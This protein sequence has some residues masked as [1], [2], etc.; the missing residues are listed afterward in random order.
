MQWIT[1][2]GYD[3]MAY[4]RFPIEACDE[5]QCVVFWNNVEGK[6]ARVRLSN[7][8][9]SEKLVLEWMRLAVADGDMIDVEHATP[10]TL[11]GSKKIELQAGQTVLSDEVQLSIPAGK[12]LAV[13]SYLR[14][15]AHIETA[16]SCFPQGNT[17]V[18]LWQGE[19]KAI[20]NWNAETP[21]ARTGLLQIQPENQCFY[22][23]AQVLVE[24]DD[25]VR[26]LACFGDS[27]THRS[28]WTAP[29]AKRLFAR[30]PGSVSVVNHGVSG[31]RILRD[32]SPFSQ[33]GKW[34]G[35][36]GRDRFERDV[37]VGERVDCVTVL[38]G[39]NDIFHPLAGDA[40]LSETVTAD[41]L[42]AGLS[43]MASVAHAHGATICGCTIT[44]FKDAFGF[45][46]AKAERV[47]TD[48]NEWL[49]RESPF[50]ACLDF[51]LYLRDPSDPERML[52]VYDCG[53]HV[54]PGAMGG[55]RIAEQIDLELLTRLL[56]LKQ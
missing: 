11:G 8:F 44:P 7:A 49:R 34:F 55:E 13:V 54:H 53:D 18:T 26:T 1:T 51:G 21:Q 5:T 3:P 10:V 19:R 2:W 6:R 27:I 15:E 14:S 48:V 29:L 45:W 46:N 35:P 39:I 16:C 9:S 50:D 42:I 43:A 12:R 36:C 30:C 28:L 40:P 31:N 4:E 22:G 20:E 37:F 47:R 56:S 52:P 33:Y 23:V 41:E 17:V 24:G 38:Q 25:G 32:D